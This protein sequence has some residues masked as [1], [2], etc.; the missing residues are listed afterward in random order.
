METI[1][2]RLYLLCCEYADKC[3]ANALEALNNATES[4]NDETKSSAGDKHETGRAMAQLEQEKSVKQ[5]S[6][7]QDL[8]NVLQKID[9]SLRSEKAGIGSVLITNKGNFYIAIAAGSLKVDDR[10]FYA[11]SPSSPIAL[12][13][14]G[15]SV[16]EKL[17]FNGQAYLITEIL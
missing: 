1:K 17:E 7:A 11:I 8:K 16:N 10:L 15:L 4:A 2:S 13:F 3:I 12:K 5:L 6:E 14:K 9:P